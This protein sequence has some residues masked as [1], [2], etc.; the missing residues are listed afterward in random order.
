MIY[1]VKLEYPNGSETTQYV[2]AES[3]QQAA[4]ETIRENPSAY[5][6]KADP[7]SAVETG[8]ASSLRNANYDSR[9]HQDNEGLQLQALLSAYFP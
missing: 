2:E 4:D 9:I 7:G 1:R 5:L 8:W 6:A 3:S